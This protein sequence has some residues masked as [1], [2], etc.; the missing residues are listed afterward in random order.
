MCVSKSVFYHAQKQVALLLLNQLFIHIFGMF[1][2]K[3]VTF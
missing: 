2:F 3:K 1:S